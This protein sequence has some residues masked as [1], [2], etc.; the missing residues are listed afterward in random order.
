MRPNSEA[1]VFQF[2]FSCKFRGWASRKNR[3][4]PSW[5]DVVKFGSAF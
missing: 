3:R 4:R 5:R 1:K 2:Y